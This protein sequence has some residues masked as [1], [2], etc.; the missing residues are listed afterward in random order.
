MLRIAVAKPL[1]HQLGQVASGPSTASRAPTV[2]LVVALE[3]LAEGPDFD[4]L[5]GRS[6]IAR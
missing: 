1:L 6:M 2:E 4:A 5:H 3:D